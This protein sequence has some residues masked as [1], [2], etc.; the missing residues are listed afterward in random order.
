[1]L[2]RGVTL[3]GSTP[4]SQRDTWEW[5]GQSWTRR[6]TQGP[7]AISGHR[8]VYDRSRGR[9]VLWTGVEGNPSSTVFWSWNGQQWVRDP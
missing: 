9:V 7:D 4:Q 1:M 5:D 3:V 2:Y 6:D 8:L